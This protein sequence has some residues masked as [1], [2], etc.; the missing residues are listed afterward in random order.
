MMPPT[1]EERIVALEAQLADLLASGAASP[2]ATLV[3][4]LLALV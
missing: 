2:V 4:T 1:S 3:V